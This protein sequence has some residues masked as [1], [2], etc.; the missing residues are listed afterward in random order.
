MS[1]EHSVC[2]ILLLFYFCCENLKN[3]KF[4][5]AAANAVQLM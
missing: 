3:K 2:V 4:S 5:S 1:V